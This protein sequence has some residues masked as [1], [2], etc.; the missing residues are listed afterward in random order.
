MKII[1]YRKGSKGLYKV[2]LEDGR[3]LSLY[4]EVIL[5]YELLL[6]R[7]VYLE[8]LEDIR[9]YNQEYEVYNVALDSIKSRFKSVYDIRE[10]LIKKEYPLDMID[11]AIEKLLKQG[12][13]NDRSFAKSYINNQ[14]I[15]TT[16]GPNKI[17][18][19]LLEHR[20]D[21]NIIDDELVVFEEDIQLE[22]IEKVANKL[23]KSNH[24]RGGVVLKRKIINDLIMLGYDNY[25]INRVIDIVDFSTNKD[26]VKKEYDKLYKRLGRKYSGAELEYKIKEK[27]YQK[28]LYYED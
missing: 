2:E 11:I 14:M 25:L 17:K 10:F 28:G 24:S 8:E 27:L 1:K 21:G 16:K 19:E 3:V 12:Y 26:I 7:E 9:K 23:L 13:L 22:K 6:K 5:K 20:V 4:E 15:T 18:K